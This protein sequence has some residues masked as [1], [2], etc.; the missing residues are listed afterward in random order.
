MAENPP[1]AFCLIWAKFCMEPVGERF[2]LTGTI[3]RTTCRNLFHRFSDIAL[4]LVIPDGIIGTLHP[5]H[6]QRSISGKPVFRNKKPQ[7]VR[8]K[9]FPFSIQNG[10][11]QSEQRELRTI[12][13]TKDDSELKPVGCDASAG[14]NGHV[15]YVILPFGKLPVNY[16]HFRQHI[17]VLPEPADEFLQCSL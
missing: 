9:K 13:K 6:H 4:G 16:L 3:S 12:I 5:E 15:S 8:K 10:I 2:I 11:F 7:S 17:L 1:I 14:G